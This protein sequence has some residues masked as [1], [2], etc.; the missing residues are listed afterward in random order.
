MNLT[1]IEGIVSL[2]D[3]IG[4]IWETAQ[5]RKYLDAIKNLKEDIRNE[6]AKGDDADLAKIEDS[7]LAM[8]E[9]VDAY[10]QELLLQAVKP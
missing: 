9:N 1:F 10:Q 6:W 4:K 7:F 3:T 2:L 5:S 8:K